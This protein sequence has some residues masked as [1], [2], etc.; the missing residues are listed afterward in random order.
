M[1]QDADK[2]PITT[3]LY[4]FSESFGQDW[5]MTSAVAVLA[6]LPICALFIIFQ[7]RFTEGLTQG[8]VKDHELSRSLLVL[9]AKLES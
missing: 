2:L 6:I 4:R 7:R 1:L 5:S 8:S 9:N 3:S